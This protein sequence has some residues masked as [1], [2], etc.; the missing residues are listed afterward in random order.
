MDSVHGTSAT[1]SGYAANLREVV[2]ALQI[3][4]NIQTTDITPGKCAIFTDNQAAI[5]AIRNPECLSG[6]YIL[7]KAVQALDELRN[8]G[9]EVEFRWIP[10]HEGVPGNEAAD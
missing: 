2:L 1:F 6:Q 10:A 3:V 9:W 4:L 7:I 5:Q 8:R